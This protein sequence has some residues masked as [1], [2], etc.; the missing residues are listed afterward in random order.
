MPVLCTPFS[1]H[2]W[3]IYTA[4]G[5]LPAWTS[6]NLPSRTL[7]FHA[8]SFWCKCNDSVIAVPG[9]G[10]GRGVAALSRQRQH[11]DINMGS[12]NWRQWIPRAVDHVKEGDAV[13][14]N[15]DRKDG[16]IYKKDAG[17]LFLDKIPPNKCQK[18]RK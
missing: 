4:Q 9:A 5:K 17:D 16:A 18:Y 3:H 6:T 13:A 8:V 15:E 7:Q 14:L 1:L 11:S 12:F 2:G 10:L